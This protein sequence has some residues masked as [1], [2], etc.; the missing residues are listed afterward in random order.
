MQIQGQYYSE[1]ILDE[2]TQIIK[3]DPEVSRRALSR[4]ICENNNWRSPNGKLKDMSCR[5]A[6][7]FLERQGLIDLPATK[8]VENFSKRSPVVVSFKSKRVSC[9]LEELGEILIKPVTSG[10]ATESRIWRSMLEQYHY[11]GP[12]PLCGAQVRYIVESASHGHIGAL[13]FSSATWALKDRDEHIGWSKAAWRENLDKVVLNARFLL[14][15]MLRVPNLASRVLSLALDRLPDDWEESYGTRPVLVETFVDPDRFTGVSY[16]AANWQHIGE[17]SGRRDGRPK[18]I[19]VYPLSRN[20]REVLCRAPEFKLGEAPRPENPAHWAEE[21]FGTIR[22]YDS[23]LKR[24]LYTIARDFFNRC[25]ANIPEACGSLARTVA[26][27]RFF[28]NKEVNMKVILDAHTEATIERIKKHQVVLA[29]QDTTILDYS[30]HPM[31]TGLG[32][33]NGIKNNS[34][35]LI[36]HDTMAFSEEGVPLGVIDAQCWARDPE[37]KGK[38]RR[39][40]EL[41]VEQKESAKWLR[42]FRRLAQIQKL[43]S[44]TTLVSIGDRESDI[45]ELLA[46]ATREADLPKL[47]V[48]A[49]RTRDRLVGGKPLWEHMAQKEPDGKL[50]VHVPRKSGLPKGRIAIVELRFAPVELA[51]PKRYA[52]EPPINLWAV[53][54]LETTP[55][56]D[57]DPVEWML[58]TT[59]EVNNFADAQNRVEWY[60]GRWGIEVYHRTLKSGCRIEDRQLGTAESLEA[61]LGVDMV[62]AWRIYHLTM[63]GR[64]A[65]DLDCTV[66]FGDVEWKA[67]CVYV[68]KNPTPPPDPPSLKEAIGMVARIGGFL[69]RKGDGVPGTTTLWR[70]LQRLDTAAEMYAIVRGEKFAPPPEAWP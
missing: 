49:E 38:S 40:K 32:P 29:P 11:L 12:G 60:A 15:P 50:Q 19:F 41:P 64:A 53:Y 54:L 33:T 22:L 13:A 58:L 46:E 26:A 27:Y 57:A 56:E 34:I 24:R 44:K 42:S 70:G 4:R 37:D 62:V 52:G 35:G 2:I 6:L 68:S 31:T 30:T 63:L 48:R 21:E 7:L 65:P 39:R 8:T 20:W 5:K 23:R 3:A 10:N 1:T 47:L 43:C 59:A 66:F 17:T 69:G 61:C 25:E 45:Y 51:P 9:T 14:L 16:R 67:L 55:D 28:K 18:K 36:L